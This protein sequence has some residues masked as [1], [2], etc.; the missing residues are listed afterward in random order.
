MS[1]RRLRETACGALAVWV[2]LASCT[3]KSHR[4]APP[5]T[6]TTQAAPAISQ[7]GDLVVGA[8]GEPGCMDWVSTCASSSWGVWTVETN[9]LPR[10]YDFARDNLYKPSILLTGEASA[11]ASGSGQVV[12][13]HVNMRAVWSDGQPITSHDFKYTWDQISHGQNIQDQSGYQD[14]VSVDDSDPQTAVV[15]FSQ[16]FADWRRLFGGVYGLL[17]SHFLEGQDRDALMKNGYNWSGGPW[18]LAPNGW[19]RGQSI[20][21]VPNPNYWGKKPDLASVTFRIFPDVATELQA[22][23]QGQVMA[24]YPVAGPDAAGFRNVPNTMFGSTGGLD[25]DALWFDVL[26]TPVNSKA[27]RQAVAYSLDRASIVSAVVGPLVS[28]VQPLQDLRTPAYGAYYGDVFSKYRP[29]TAVVVQLMQGDG[30]VKGTDGIWAKAG[31]KATIELK[32]SNASAQDQL[33]AARIATQLQAAGFGATVNAEAPATLF[34]TD[35]PTGSFTAAVYPLDLGRGQP[36]VITVG[37]GIED[38]DPG[39]CRLFCTSRIPQASADGTTATTSSTTAAARPA[40]GATGVDNFTRVSDPTLDRYLADLDVNLSDSARMADA[41]QAA[42]LLGE[43]VPAIPLAA[44]PDIVVV[45]TA[46]VGI[47]GGTFSHNLSYGP[48][49]SLNEWYLK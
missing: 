45:N 24:A 33:Y 13:Y 34:G 2:L 1:G 27:V 41:G 10:A 21:L 15:T 32:V 49:S 29:D 25:Y 37:V 35:L 46:K 8:Q 48:Y 9:T 6:V 28:G 18:Q 17:P 42:S 40:T 12:T 47:E 7:G 19:V 26:R 39:Q 36:G 11:Q 30:W 5:T 16:P 43:L 44:V 20:K 22:Y 31:Q 3:G 14:I 23:S 4:P 38:N